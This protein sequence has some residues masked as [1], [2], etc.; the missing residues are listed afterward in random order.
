MVMVTKLR[1]Y[2]NNHPIVH[3]KQVKF[4]SYKYLSKAIIKRLKPILFIWD[5]QQN[6]QFK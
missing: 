6:T 3:F 4:M 5:R 2:S 1:T